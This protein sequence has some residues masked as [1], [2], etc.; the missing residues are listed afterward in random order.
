MVRD[1]AR[2]AFRAAQ[3]GDSLYES[4]PYPYQSLDPQGRILFV[5]PAW[6]DLFGYDIGEVLGQSF[7]DFLSEESR[8]LLNER[9]E[10][11]K[12]VGRVAGYDFHVRHRLGSLM[13]VR[14]DGRIQRSADGSVE[15]THCFLLDMRP[16]LQARQALLESERG[17]R[18]MVE[19][20]LGGIWEIDA[21]GRTTFVNQALADMLGY[22]RQEI[23]DRPLFDFMDERGT[24]LATRLLA[25]RARGL[26]DQHD[27]EFLTKQGQRITVFINTKPLQDARGR[28]AGAVAE[29]IDVTWRRLHEKEMF[30]TQKMES[31]GV[32]AGGIA[33]DFNN[34][35]QTVVGNVDLIEQESTPEGC[36]RSYLQEIR[37]AAAR[38]GDLCRQ[39]LSYAGRADFA[40]EEVDVGGLVKEMAAIVTVSLDRNARLALDIADG[41]P[42]VLGDRGQLRQMIMNLAANASEAL[43]GAAGTVTIAVRQEVLD[44][45]DL[46][47]RFPAATLAGGPCVVI[48]V[49]DTGCGM[50][51]ETLKRMFDPFFSSKFAG[52]GMGLAAVMGIISAHNGAVGVRSAPWQ[53]TT[54]EVA[55]PAALPAAVGQAVTRSEGVEQDKGAGDRSPGGEGARDKGAMERS[56]GDQGVLAQDHLAQDQDGRRT[57]LVAD[58]EDLVLRLVSRMLIN[59]GYRVLCARDGREAARLHRDNVG[60][61]RAVL[62]DMTMPVMGGQEAFL[63]IHAREPEVPVF[64]F[65]GFPAEDLALKFP[66]PKPTAFL[67]KPFSLEGLK[68]A[69]DSLSRA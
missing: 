18:A 37:R 48:T 11:F 7:A 68:V 21:E 25:R 31:L 40:L 28:Y 46:S 16:E 17:R 29:V 32:L 45:E 30:H 47:R 2:R 60:R 4:A 55:L 59:L 8:A 58:D 62:L 41:L 64:I 15:R 67:Q 33:H 27:F 10:R 22:T 50:D 6:L 61:I 39:M 54:V 43:G 1:P 38:A 5:N 53:G 24:Q 23:L 52:R 49:E 9:F 51:P 35:L 3:G 12:T 44:V 56:A 13:P 36:P 42:P 19:R 34:M 57:V 66:E 69:L 63:E 14:L 65:S 26:S 20:A